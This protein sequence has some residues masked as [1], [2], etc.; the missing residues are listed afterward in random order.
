MV[1]V[2]FMFPYHILIANGYIPTICRVCIDIDKIKDVIG[3]HDF[4]FK[5][6]AGLLP[7]IGVEWDCLCTLG[8]YQHGKRRNGIIVISTYSSSL[9]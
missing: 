4:F 1:D 2:R 5:F 8:F 3:K 7:L 6:A 9:L